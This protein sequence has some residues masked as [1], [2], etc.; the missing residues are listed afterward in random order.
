VYLHGTIAAIEP[1]T[2][3]AGTF[4]DCVRVDYVI[5][6]G[7][8]QCTDN[9]GNI[10]GTFRSETRGHVHYAPGVG[11]VDSKEDFIP[12]A[13]LTGACGPEGVGEV[14]T[15]VTM[16]LDALPTAVRRSSWGQLKLVYR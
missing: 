1:A 13:E 7:M 12:N 3:A 14:S 10:T 15:R 16:S 8:S 11:P 4:T 6:Y 9:D 2:V 5:D